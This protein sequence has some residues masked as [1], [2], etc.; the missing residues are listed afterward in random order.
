MP[1]SVTLTALEG[2]LKGSIYRLQERAVLLVGKEV[3]C[4]IRLPQDDLHRTISR[5]HCLLDI[6]PPLV[7]LRDLNSRNGTFVNGKRIGQGARGGGHRSRPH[8]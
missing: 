6:S 3:D 7:R 2:A 4:H 8:G 1:A 5:H